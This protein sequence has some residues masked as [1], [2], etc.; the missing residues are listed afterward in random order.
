M[1]QMQIHILGISPVFP[2]MNEMR[3]SRLCVQLRASDPM[4]NSKD[5]LSE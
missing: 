5:S 2:P 3:S 4:P 1:W